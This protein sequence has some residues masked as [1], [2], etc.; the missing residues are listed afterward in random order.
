[1]KVGIIGGTSKMG[2][3]L[4]IRLALMCARCIEA[5]IMINV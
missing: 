5:V 2:R 3:G 4:T 1:M